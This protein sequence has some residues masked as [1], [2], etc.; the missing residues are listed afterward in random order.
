MSNHATWVVVAN[1][2]EARIFKLIK[3]PK[4]EELDAL[5]HPESHLHN[6]DLVSSKPGRTFQSTNPN[7]SAYEPKTSPKQNEIDKFARQLGEHLATTLHNGDFQ[8][9]YLFAEP[10]FLGNLRQHLDAKTKDAIVGEAPKDLTKH[11][12]ADIERSL[13]EVTI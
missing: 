3:F 9:L 7:R 4:I 2:C 1:S 11:K 10:S 12:I 6:Q 5:Y 8:R 13:E